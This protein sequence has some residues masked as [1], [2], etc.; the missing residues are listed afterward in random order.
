MVITYNEIFSIILC[1]HAFGRKNRASCSI[2]AGQ[3]C[4][5]WEG[6]CVWMAIFGLGTGGAGGSSSQCSSTVL[7]SQE[8]QCFVHKEPP[9]LRR[10]EQGTSE[11]HIY[12]TKLGVLCIPAVF[13]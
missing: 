11:T 3:G 2:T 6:K 9:T 10:A 7:G 5:P 12:V 13:L 4:I 8:K 1:L